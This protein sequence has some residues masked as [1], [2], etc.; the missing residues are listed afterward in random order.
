[1]KLIVSLSV[2]AVLAFV[3]GCA[4]E[5]KVVS[6]ESAAGHWV[7]VEPELGSNIRRRVWVADGSTNEVGNSQVR[8]MSSDAL[9]DLPSRGNVTS[10]RPGQ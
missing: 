5:N 1:M 3:T 6:K 9:R 4:S 7:T 10:G 2:A 8:T